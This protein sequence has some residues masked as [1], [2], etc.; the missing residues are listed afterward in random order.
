LLVAATGPFISR[1]R[2]SAIVASALDGINAGSLGLMAAVTYF[3]GRAAIFDL[4]TALL[5]AASAVLLWWLRVNSVWIIL[6]A[7]V[8]GALWR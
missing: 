5:A 8:A 4:G 3:L 2:K 7:A 6:A 1:L